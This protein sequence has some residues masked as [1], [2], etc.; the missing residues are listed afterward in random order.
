MAKSYTKVSIEQAL[1][2]VSPDVRRAFELSHEVLQRVG[3]PHVLVG[4]LAVNAYGHHYSTA[5]VD[6]L[7]DPND[8]F[9]GTLVVTHKPGVPFRIG[10][11]NVDYVTAAPDFPEVIRD[12]MANVVE[13]AR[14]HP[15]MVVVIPDGLLVWMKL[16]AGRSKDVAAVEGMLAAGLDVDTVREFLD[17]VGDTRVSELFERCV[18]RVEQPRKGR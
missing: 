13:E 12:A 9:E 4:G 3:V 10:D 17:Q 11:V 6:Y 7:V 5:D 15:D 14:Q 18:R 1:K 16:N 2:S 8:V